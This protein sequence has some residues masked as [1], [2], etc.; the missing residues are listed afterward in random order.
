MR[1]KKEIDPK[2]RSKKRLYLVFFLFAIL[3]GILIYRLYQLTVVHHAFLMEQSNMRM[4]RQ[5]DTTHRRGHILDQNKH[6]LAVSLPAYTVWYNPQTL[7]PENQPFQNVLN[8]LGLQT[9]KTK[10]EIYKNKKKRKHFAYLKRIV[11]PETLKPFL[12]MML[13]GLHF[14]HTYKRYYPQGAM[15]TQLLGIT[16][17]DGKGIEGLEWIFN[18]HLAGRPGKII[19]QMN[20]RKETIDQLFIKLEI[21]AKDLTLTLD[22]K[23]QY[24]A[25]RALENG[26]KKTQAESGSVVILSNTGAILA[27]VNVPSVNPNTLTA[28]NVPFG[29]L[30]NRAVTDLFEPGSTVKPI[31]LANIL[32]SKRYTLKDMVNITGG[33]ITLQRHTIT[34]VGKHLN[35]LSVL[36]ILKKS[37]NVGFS[38]LTLSLPYGSLPKMFGRFGFGQPTFSGLPG[39]RAGYLQHIGPKDRLTLATLS[40]GYGMS[41]NL[42]QLAQAYEILANEGVYYPLHI[43]QKTRPIEK[44]TRRILDKTIAKQVKYALSQATSASGTGSHAR[45]K[46]YSIAGKTGTSNILGK[47]GYANT[48]TIAS[49]VGFAPVHNTRYIVAV[50][51]RKPSYSKRYGGIAAAP[52]FSNIMSNIM[53]QENN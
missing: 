16:N 51:I 10:R 49:F 37:S 9:E 19:K 27:L 43:I 32:S 35:H 5:V 3:S 8:I 25:Y 34:D 4:T 24:L 45:I 29:L 15:T 22:R 42:L 36:D 53:Q 14:R 1:R 2:M 40:F 33:K 21:P 12:N 44:S 17:V 46:G 41:V 48:K 30:K 39:E 13:P 6:P 31:S 47:N 18:R 20:A 50:V 26:V 52:I 28:Q 7:D 38:R 11:S 23:I